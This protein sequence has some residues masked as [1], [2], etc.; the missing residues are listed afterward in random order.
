MNM[1]E[2][3]ELLETRQGKKSDEQYANEIGFRGSTMWRYKNG[4]SRI[5]NQNR[6]MMIRYFISVNDAAGNQSR[7]PLFYDAEDS[8]EYLGTIIVDPEIDSALPVLHWFVEDIQAADTFTGT[9]ASLYY[10]GNFYDNVYMRLR[11]GAGYEKKNYK[12]DLN[13]SHWFQFDPDE[14]LVEE[15]N[16]NHTQGDSA[17]VREPL[18][19]TRTIQ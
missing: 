3:M 5:N 16:V 8:P 9:R 13:K 2:L 15:F 12:F 4:K 1:K 11:G 10:A 19:T 7:W 17:Y 14:A 6:E 18:G